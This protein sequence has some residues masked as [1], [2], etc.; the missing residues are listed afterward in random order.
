MDYLDSDG[1]EEEFT[2][3]ENDASTPSCS[4]CPST[5]TSST[6]TQVEPSTSY[7]SLDNK[8]CTGTGADTSTRPPKAVEAQTNN[9][10]LVKSNE[11]KLVQDEAALSQMASQV[12]EQTEV[13]G[14]QDTGNT[15]HEK[16]CK[17]HFAVFHRE[18]SRCH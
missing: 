2:P 1:D 9:D 14:D 15:S 13:Y 10:E 18:G 5:V 17:N 4:T 16:V 11:T 12:K 6:S 8:C 7:A 3:L